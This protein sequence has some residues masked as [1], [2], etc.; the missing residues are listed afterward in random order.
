M[1]IKFIK[2]HHL[3]I[4]IEIGE[5]FEVF[6]RMEVPCISNLVHASMRLKPDD[7]Q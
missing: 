7:W 3:K 6:T 1:A 2:K 5:W 4:G